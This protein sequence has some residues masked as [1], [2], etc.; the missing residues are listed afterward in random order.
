[1][2]RCRL[3]GTLTGFFEK[4][5]AANFSLLHWQ[6]NELSLSCTVI[7][8][9]AKGPNVGLWLITIDLHTSENRSHALYC[10]Q[11]SSAVSFLT[12]IS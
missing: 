10:V 5:A 3:G 6:G 12:P 1:M 9:F 7:S 11:S 8:Y 2:V 4:F